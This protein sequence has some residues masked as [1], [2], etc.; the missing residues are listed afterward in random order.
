MRQALLTVAL[1]V[2]MV[3]A[4]RA[5]Q[6]PSLSPQMLTMSSTISHTNCLTPALGQTLYCFAGDGAWIS[7]NGAAY[8]QFAP[9]AAVATGVASIS[10][11]G[12]TPQTGAVALTI[13]TSAST[14]VTSTAVTTIK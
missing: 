11:N 1:I 5:A 13:P 9:P 7:V 4:V 14:T 3:V 2:A 12:A 6:N 10:V 8:V